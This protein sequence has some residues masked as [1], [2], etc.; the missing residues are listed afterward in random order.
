[1]TAAATAGSR[2]GRPWRVV[3]DTHVVVSALL[4]A[5]GPTAR[6][7]QAWLAGEV[8][9]LASRATVAELMR[10]LSYPKFRLSPDERAELLADYLPA[11]IVVTVPEPAPEVPLCRDP[12][13][14]VF[15]QLAAAGKADALVTGDADLMALAGQTRWRIVTPAELVGCLTPRTGG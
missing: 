12:H 13:D 6:V 11:A 9:P 10:V 3:L 8:L 1:M 4:F 5:R 7:R 2:V 14:L 15:L